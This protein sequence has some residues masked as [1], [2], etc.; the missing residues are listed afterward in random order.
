MECVAVGLSQESF[1]LEGS[2][3]GW[4]ACSYGYHS[5]DGGV[6]HASGHS[7]DTREPFGVG[8]VVGCGMDFSKPDGADI[9]FTKNGRFL[10]TF[11]SNVQASHGHALYPTVGLDAAL[12]LKINFGD[13]PFVY[14]V[15]AMTKDVGVGL[16]GIGIDI[17]VGLSNPLGTSG[18]HTSMVAMTQ[19]PVSE[20]GH[21]LPAHG[22]ETWHAESRRVRVGFGRSRS[23]SDDND[24]DGGAHGL[25]EL[26]TSGLRGIRS[27]R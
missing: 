18:H 14:D 10:G 5:D 16:V 27:R 24:G 25:V 21:K 13:E 26:V 2:M 3:P 7:V 20:E 22:P 8:D 17:G 19:G 15:G 12:T 23:N 1:P 4:D 9:F 6:F 11:F